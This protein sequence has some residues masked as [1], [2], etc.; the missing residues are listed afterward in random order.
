MTLT[1]LTELLHWAAMGSSTLGYVIDDQIIWD[2]RRNR[3][4]RAYRPFYAM[5][6]LDGVSYNKDG[7]VELSNVDNYV[8]AVQVSHWY[9]CGL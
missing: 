5:K 6:M 3:Q 4:T 7:W 2:P 1:A 8:Y 9:A